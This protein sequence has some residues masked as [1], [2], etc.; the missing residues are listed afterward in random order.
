MEN[1]LKR[2]FQELSTEAK[3]LEASRRMQYRAST[4]TNEEY[5]DSNALLNWKVKAKSLLVSACGEASQHFKEFDQVSQGSLYSTNLDT[6]RRMMAVFEA[7]R[8]DFEGGYLASVRDLVRAEV[9]GSELE[10]AS[11]LLSP[12]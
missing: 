5:V 2:R 9:F 1:V 12:E 3:M 10:Q 6:L 4:G 7:A 11:A 8:E